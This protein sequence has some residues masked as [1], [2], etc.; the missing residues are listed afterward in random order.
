M[1]ELIY[2]YNNQ[3]TYDYMSELIHHAI[4][5]TPHPLVKKAFE[6]ALHAQQM[7]HALKEVYDKEFTICDRCQKNKRSNLFIVCPSC[8]DEVCAEHDKYFIDHC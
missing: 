5:H 1:D 4:E 6:E 3:N 8:W 7:N 2:K